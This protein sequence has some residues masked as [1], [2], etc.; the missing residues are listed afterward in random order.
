[1]A[2]EADGAVG[3]SI[4]VWLTHEAEADVEDVAVRVDV[5]VDED[6]AEEEVEIVEAVAA[7]DDCFTDLFCLLGSTFTF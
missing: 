7:R 6:G 5:D 1:V 4:G 2:E 3:V